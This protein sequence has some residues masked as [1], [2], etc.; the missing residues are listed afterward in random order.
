M[1]VFPFMGIPPGRSSIQ[2]IHGLDGRWRF[3]SEAV[4]LATF[5]Q[6]QE[7]NQMG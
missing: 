5:H 7:T 3:S 4:G 1:V 2:I 6:L